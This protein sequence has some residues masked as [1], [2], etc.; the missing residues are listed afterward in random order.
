MNLYKTI[1][2]SA[3]YK[4]LGIAICMVGVCVALM[5]RAEATPMAFGS[6]AYEFVQ[7]T[8]PFGGTPI[9]SNNSWFTASAA[10]SASVFGGVS[11]HLATITSAAENAFLIGLTSGTFT[12]FQGAWIGGI[13][14]AG[15]LVGPE[16]GQAFSYTNWAG[17]EPNNSG[18][19]YML[20]SHP[21]FASGTWADDSLAQG[22]GQ[23]FPD[24]NADPVIGYFVEW[25]N[26]AAFVS[27]PEPTTLALLSLGLFG[28]GFNRRKRLQ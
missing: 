25:E 13:A 3:S 26:A 27:A 5:P 15:W 12:G 20:L 2:A 10:A 9:G 11:G 28:L 7:V 16:T 4:F 1:W 18:Y 17:I 19:A 21:S 8:N 24:A 22:S 6:N 23:G 14:P